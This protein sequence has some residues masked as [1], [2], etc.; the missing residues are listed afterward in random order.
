MFF[1]I[2]DKGSDMAKKKVA[3]KKVAEKTVK[4]AKAT[5]KKKKAVAKKKAASKPVAVKKQE[6][7]I[8]KK[9]P[10]IDIMALQKAF[11]G[12]FKDALHVKRIIG[13]PA[14]SIVF[15]DKGSQKRLTLDNAIETL[16]K[17]NK[18]LKEMKAEEVYVVNLVS[19]GGLIEVRF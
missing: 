18:A 5:P 4:T 19:N 8:V 12:Q 1:M 11:E 2:V 10:V 15:Q 7:V 14:V 13:Q 16:S 17:V 6:K 3:K 9:D